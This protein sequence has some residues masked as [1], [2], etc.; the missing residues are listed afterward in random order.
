MRFNI[1][2]VQSMLMKMDADGMK[3][4]V[5]ILQQMVNSNEVSAC[6]IIT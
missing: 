2:N 4:H 3:N 6:M 1:Y 5:N